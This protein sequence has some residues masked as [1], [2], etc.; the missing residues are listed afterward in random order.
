MTKE[1]PQ[2]VRAKV[3]FDAGYRT[4]RL[5]TKLGKIP[6]RSAERYV[7]QFRK[8]QDHERKVKKR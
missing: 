5:L 7:S 1:I 8:G 2:K 3:L 6:E 4:P